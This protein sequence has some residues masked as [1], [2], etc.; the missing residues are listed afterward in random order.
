MDGVTLPRWHEA[1]TVEGPTRI[2]VKDERERVENAF[3][4][5]PFVAFAGS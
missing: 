1:R 4:R 2:Q 3:R 5:A